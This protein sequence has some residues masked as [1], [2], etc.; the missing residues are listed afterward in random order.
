MVREDRGGVQSFSFSRRTPEIRQKK[1]EEIYGRGSVFAALAVAKNVFKC[2]IRRTE[3]ASLFTR[4][5]MEDD[6]EMPLLRSYDEG[7]YFYLIFLLP[8][9]NPV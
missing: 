6:P 8:V 1:Q 3:E 4:K 2:L 9:E 5:P 7:K